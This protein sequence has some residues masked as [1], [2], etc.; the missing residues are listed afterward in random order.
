M[1]KINDTTA[2]PN[3]SSSTGLVLIASQSGATK[4]VPVGTSAGTFAAG[5][6]SRITGA[7]QSPQTAV[8]NG[9]TVL[10]LTPTSTTSDY[11]AVVL[12]AASGSANTA[13][14]MWV[15]E[16]ST[17][18]AG[19]VD[20]LMRI[21]YNPKRV[22]TTEPSC[23]IVIESNYQ[24]GTRD[25]EFYIEYFSYDGTTSWRPFF[26]GKDK[27][28]QVGGEN[29][30]VAAEV[31]HCK[32]TRASPSGLK[33]APINANQNAFICVDGSDAL[34]G[35]GTGSNQYLELTGGKDSSNGAMIRLGGVTYGNSSV[36]KGEVMLT[37]GVVASQSGKQG[38]IVIY[39]G[40]SA[41][42]RLRVDYAGDTTL[43]GNMKLGTA[44]NGLYVKEGTNACMGTLTLN[45][46]TEVT[47]NTTKVT[48]NSRIFLTVQ[49]PG[50]TPAG[51]AYVSSRSAGTSFGVKGIA[52]DTST[53]AW[54]IVEPA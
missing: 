29:I 53:V 34:S 30:V 10:A 23:N 20:P 46:A 9:A 42:E 52:A 3:A 18:F 25:L 16:G 26:F 15:Y 32:G 45:G 35:T 27:S 40:A 41:T 44:G 37:G 17:S 24:H 39:T 54:L 13:A 7:V 2:Y 12:N 14:F 6:D 50:G 19:E 28:T 4:T 1:P 49:A 48:A 51:V 21:G 22:V 11:K 36:A 33:L 5:D 47:V 43:A 38:A 31:I 8:A